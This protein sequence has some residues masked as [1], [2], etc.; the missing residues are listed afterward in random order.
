MNNSMVR[1][2]KT[3]VTQLMERECLKPM[4]TNLGWILMANFSKFI[5]RT[6]GTHIEMVMDRGQWNARTV[7]KLGIPQTSVQNDQ[8]RLSL[9][10]GNPLE[11][12]K[13]PEK[14]K[15]KAVEKAKEKGGKAMHSVTQNSTLKRKVSIR[16]STHARQTI[17]DEV[18]RTHQGVALGLADQGTTEMGEGVTRID[19]GM[20]GDIRGTATP[21]TID[22]DSTVVRTGVEGSLGITGTSLTG[23]T[24]RGIDLSPMG[25]AGKE[26]VRSEERKENIRM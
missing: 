15:A 26:G 25:G 14:G 13:D 21:V 11:M 8:V 24:L 4:G 22:V 5:G 3:R 6:R 16:E 17:Q 23:H 9:F 2:A 20:S 10:N 12:E 19:A 7:I 1:R 18:I